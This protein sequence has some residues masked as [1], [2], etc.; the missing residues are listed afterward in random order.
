M[1]SSVRVPKI[2]GAHSRSN[3]FSS[4]D[5]PQPVG[6]QIASFASAQRQVQILQRWV[7]IPWVN[8]RTSATLIRGGV[9]RFALLL[10]ITQWLGIQQDFI[11]AACRTEAGGQ[12]LK[13]RRQR[14][15][16]LKRGD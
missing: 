15:D 8:K 10:A 5:L 14:R 6:A 7:A 12:M 3:R 1:P 4:V 2:V 16:G 9:Y 13:G 11:Q